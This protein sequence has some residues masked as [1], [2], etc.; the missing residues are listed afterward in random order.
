MIV[1]FF[2]LFYISPGKHP[3][4][5]IALSSLSEAMYLIMEAT[6][7]VICPLHLSKFMALSFNLGPLIFGDQTTASLSTWSHLSHYQDIL[8]VNLKFFYS[9]SLVLTLLFNFIIFLD[10]YL[11]LTKPFYPR[12]WRSKYFFAFAIISS[13]LYSLS[14]LLIAKPLQINRIEISDTMDTVYSLSLGTIGFFTFILVLQV[15]WILQRQ[16]TSR[17]LKQ[18]VCKRYIVYSFL[19]LFL[20][21]EFMIYFLYRK[22]ESNAF[23]NFRQ[24]CMIPIGISLGVIRLFEPYVWQN[25]K[26][27]I[28]KQEP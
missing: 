22:Y 20:L 8:M 6:Y 16:G 13:L 23:F 18:K 7:P 14:F 4:Q 27:I 24:I 11:T 19:Y 12:E 3:Y 1:G 21:L 25:F 17:V 15:V 10:L 2:I 28:L 9:L 26:E 5:F